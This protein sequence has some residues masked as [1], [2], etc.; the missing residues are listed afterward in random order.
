MGDLDGDGDLE[1]VVAS[2]DY[3][4]YALN[5]DGSVFW[6]YQTDGY[7]YYPVLG[8]IDGDNQLEVVVRSDDGKIHALDGDGSFLWGYTAFFAASA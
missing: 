6:T 3:T 7:A 2:R 4:V 5:A 1:I 8:D